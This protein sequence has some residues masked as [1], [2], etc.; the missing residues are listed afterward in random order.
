ML[1]QQ[2][3]QVIEVF[4]TFNSALEGLEDEDNR[5]ERQAVRRIIKATSFENVIGL[6]E[7]AVTHIDETYCPVITKPTQLEKKFDKLGAYIRRQAEPF[8]GRKVW[9][10]GEKPSTSPVVPVTTKPTV[11][12]KCDKCNNGWIRTARGMPQCGCMPAR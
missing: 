1:N 8:G 4:K 10:L 2:T 3:N 7:Y 11:I 12:K 9:G 5:A 6:A